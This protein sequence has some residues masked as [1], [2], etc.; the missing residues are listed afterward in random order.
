MPADAAHPLEST[1][2]PVGETQT[3]VVVSL[4]HLVSHFYIMVLP[5]LLPLLKERLG[6]SFLDLG[7][8]LTTFNV[9]TALTQAPMGFVVDRLGPARC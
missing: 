2:R 7:L 4:A 1:A 3:L 9:V 8:A 6:V 5:V